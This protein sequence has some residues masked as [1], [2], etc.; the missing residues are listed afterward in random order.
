[1]LLTYYCTEITRDNDYKFKSQSEGT[2]EV[3]V[4]SKSLDRIKAMLHKYSHEHSKEDG[5]QLNGF[6]NYIYLQRPEHSHRYWKVVIG[7]W[8]SKKDFILSKDPERILRITTDGFNTM[9]KDK[10]AQSYIEKLPDKTYDDF[11]KTGG[12]LFY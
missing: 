2:G 9:I 6:I 12:E 4:T 3:I 10:Y 1:M 11:L 8:R 5:M 7:V